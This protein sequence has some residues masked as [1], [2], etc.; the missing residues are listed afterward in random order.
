MQN[1][2]NRIVNVRKDNKWNAIY[3]SLGLLKGAP[4]LDEFVHLIG[5]YAQNYEQILDTYEYYFTDNIDSYNEAW[6]RLMGIATLTDE[7]YRDI[8]FIYSFIFNPKNWT[9]SEIERYELLEK[10]MAKI[11]NSNARLKEEK[12]AVENEAYAGAVAEAID[13]LR[14]GKSS[15]GIMPTS[16]GLADKI[17]NYTQEDWDKEVKEVIGNVEDTTTEKYVDKAKKTQSPAIKV[18]M[19]LIILLSG[20]YVPYNMWK[21]NSGERQSADAFIRIF[22]GLVIGFMGLFIVMTITG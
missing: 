3:Q 15:G 5:D 9:G 22:V 7:V 4:L 19:V 14:W 11:R 10:M 2:F 21:V 1:R 12:E 8:D 16:P 17:A 18:G 20:F 6:D 13:L